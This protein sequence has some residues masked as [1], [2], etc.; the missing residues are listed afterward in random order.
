[1]PIAYPCG[2]I[3]ARSDGSWIVARTVAAMIGPM[4][5]MLVSRRA[6]SSFF[7]A[8]RTFVSSAS[9]R[10]LVLQYAAGE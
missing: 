10:R 4:P 5:G 7:T 3:A 6:V 8:A 9:N 2:E 1:M